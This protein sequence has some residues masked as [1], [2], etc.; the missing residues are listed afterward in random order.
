MKLFRHIPFFLYVL[1]LYNILAFSGGTEAQRIMDA[2]LIQMRL[3]SGATFILDVNDLLIILGVIA[4]CIEIFKS[5]RTSNVSI[6]DHALSMLVFVVFLIEFIVVEKA[7]TSSF[8]I[9]TLM[10]LIDVITGFTVTISS[11]RRDL[12]IIRE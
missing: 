9:L 11:S 1:I 10:A 5:T 6:I 12:S 8:L 2:T 4:L 7:G 3:L